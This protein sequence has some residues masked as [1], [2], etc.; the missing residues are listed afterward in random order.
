MQV[1]RLAPV[2]G[3]AASP[4]RSKRDP[5]PKCLASSIASVAAS[6]AWWQ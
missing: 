6:S 4:S 5:G 1:A 3:E 2:V